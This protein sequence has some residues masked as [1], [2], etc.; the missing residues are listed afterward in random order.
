MM[1]GEKGEGRAGPGERKGEKLSWVIQTC[2]AHLG[3]TLMSLQTWNPMDLLMYPS[4]QR[5]Q[6]AKIVSP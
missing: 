3:L 6:T 1:G 5:L 4:R 2:T